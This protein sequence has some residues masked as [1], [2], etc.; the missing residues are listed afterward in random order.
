[1]CGGGTRSQILVEVRKSG[2]SAMEALAGSVSMSLVVKTKKTNVTD[3]VRR[4]IAMVDKDLA[5]TMIKIM[6]VVTRRMAE[7]RIDSD[8][9]TA[10]IAATDL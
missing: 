1:M 10:A 5:S 2:V 9:T 4:E 7:V 8:I 6:M 3:G